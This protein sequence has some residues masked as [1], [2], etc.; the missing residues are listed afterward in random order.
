MFRAINAFL[1]TGKGGTV[2]LGIVDE[3]VVKG[4][5]LSQYQVYFIDANTGWKINL[6]SPKICIFT[7]R[8]RFGFNE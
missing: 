7:E 1:N 3:G 2:Y 5:R 6:C 4:I 8:S